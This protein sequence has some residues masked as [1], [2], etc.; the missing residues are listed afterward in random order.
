[1]MTCGKGVHSHLT[2]LGPIGGMGR[3]GKE[4]EKREKEESFSERSSTFSLSF[5]TIGPA[6]LG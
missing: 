6:V 3:E 1:M 5:P 4:R 2:H